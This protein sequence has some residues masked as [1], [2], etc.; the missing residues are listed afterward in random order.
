MRDDAKTHAEQ[1]LERRGAAD[2]RNLADQ[3]IYTA[4]KIMRDS[5]DKLSESTKADLQAKIDGLRADIN[6]DRYD[7]VE[8]KTNDLRQMIEAA[9]VDMNAQQEAQVG[10]SAPDPE[11][12]ETSDQDD[13]VDG[14]IEDA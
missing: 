13:V 14:E 5:G 12:D 1:D 7:E 10:G 4:E 11:G 2:T 9:G 8:Q 3:T 6:T